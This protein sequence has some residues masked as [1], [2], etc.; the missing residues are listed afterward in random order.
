MG[1][2]AMAS[3]VSCVPGSE[4][5]TAPSGD[6]P[7]DILYAYVPD[8]LDLFPGQL[9]LASLDGKTTQ[10]LLTLPEAVLAPRWSPDGAR[11]LFRRGLAPAQRLPLWIVQSDGTGLRSLPTELDRVGNADWSPDGQWIVYHRVTIFDKAEIAAMRPDGTGQHAIVT[12]LDDVFGGPSWSR[13][14]RIAFRRNGAEPGIWTVNADGSGLMRLTTGP[15]DDSPLWSPD[16]KQLAFRDVVNPSQQVWRYA[17][18]V[19]NADG[20]GRRMLTTPEENT[21]EGLFDWS[22]DGDRILY[23]R[24][25]ISQP[26]MPPHNAVLSVPLAGGAPV[27]VLPIQPLAKFDGASWRAAP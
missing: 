7:L 25:L 6:L 1:L 20:T 19:V 18:A 22:P 5:V 26:P 4:E 27:E 11:I 15:N 9:R 23:S 3:A 8:Q 16:G 14:G 21:S 24:W 13:G 17:I 10:S 2:F 12:G